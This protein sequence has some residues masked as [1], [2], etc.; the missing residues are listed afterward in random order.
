MVPIREDGLVRAELIHRRGSPPDAEYTFKHALVQDAA[1]D[2]MLRGRRQQLH[3]HIAATLGRRLPKPWR[4][5]GAGWRWSPPCPMAN[6]VGKTI[7]LACLG[8]LDRA[9]ARA[10]AGLA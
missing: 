5:S 1:Y 8:Y 9:A 6:G 4:C 2:T 7:P 10:E 3:A